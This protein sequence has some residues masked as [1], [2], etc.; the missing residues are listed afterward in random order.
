MAMEF[1]SKFVVFSLHFG[2]YQL[3]ICVMK[4][5][6]QATRL[7]GILDTG[8]VAAENMSRVADALLAGG[9][10]VLQ[11][12]AKGMT[13]EQVLALIERHLPDLGTKCK[14]YGVPFIINDFSEVALAVSADGVHIGQGDGTLAGVRAVVGDEM[15]VGRST[16][17]VEQA[18]DALA[19]GFDYI[20]YGPLFPT[21][22]KQG[23]PG[24]GLEGIRAVQK[25]VGK[26]IPVFCIGGIKP[27]NLQLVLASGAYRVVIVSA[28]L[29][30][31]DVLQSTSKVV[32]TIQ[33]FI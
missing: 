8:Y 17:S 31:E 32:S 5:M 26:S 25:S 6:Q 12:R 18:Q 7:Y 13:A 11:L 21:P 16:H 1:R 27:E 33:S 9:V 22:T 29:Q 30:A 3:V 14:E 15:I 2:V 24:I 20:G 4:R 10:G 19:E 28:L 23:R